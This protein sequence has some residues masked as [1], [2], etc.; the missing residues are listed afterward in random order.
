MGTALGGAWG[1]FGAGACGAVADVLTHARGEE[2]GLLEED[3]H[4]LPQGGAS[5]VVGVVAVEVDVSLFGL[6]QAQ[7]LSKH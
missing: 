7:L 6:G 4:V 1:A 2:H 3:G 5:D